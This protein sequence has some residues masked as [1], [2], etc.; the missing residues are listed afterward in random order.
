MLSRPMRDK[1][2]EISQGSLPSP[3]RWGGGREGAATR[4]VR[5]STEHRQ[6]FFINAISKLVTKLQ[7]TRD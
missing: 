1:P 2:I 3:L 7:A 5:L 6:G 4:R